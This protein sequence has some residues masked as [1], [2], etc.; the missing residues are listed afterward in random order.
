MVTLEFTHRANTECDDCNRHCT[1]GFYHLL[2]GTPILFFCTMCAP[3]HAHK[4]MIDEA[5]DNHKSMCFSMNEAVERLA[6]N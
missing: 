5:L 2:D 6:L 4:E 3:H 1:N